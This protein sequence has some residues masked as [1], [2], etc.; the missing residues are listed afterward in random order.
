MIG[1][2]AILEH[3]SEDLRET[4]RTIAGPDCDLRFAEG[5]DEASFRAA[6]DGAVYAVVRGYALPEAVLRAAPSVRM[7]HQW[8]TGTDGIPVAAAAQMG[9][10]VAR[11]PGVNAPTVA[12][13]ALGM[14]LSTLRRIP[15]THA[16]LRGGQWGMPDLWD[17]ARDLAG[18]E[19]GLIGFGAIG[20]AVAARLEGFGCTIRYWR[21]SGPM[22]GARG[23]YADLDTLLQASDVV[24]LHVPL[25]DGTRHLMNAE[26]LG[27][28]K[29]GAI[30][31][32]TGRGGL[33]DEA[34]LLAAL[35]SGRLVGAGLDV[36]EQEPTPADNPL[37][38]HDSVV[39][40]PHVAG[41][42]RDNLHRM[43]GYWM[44]NIKRH[45]A[46]EVIDPKDVVQPS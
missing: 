46:G 30:L 21:R 4:I 20:Q 40:M 42:T 19:V 33:V 26:R 3:L 23:H 18:A 7:V 1:P 37:L 6:L 24:S 11:C 32:N 5:N 14:M 39:V 8:G 36:F 34:A 35:N 43:V 27:L 31:I 41:R 10:T 45:A 29:P 25:T 28:M 12:D 13:L 16:A 2:I 22:Q 15:Q 17:K 38:K 44:A 9:I